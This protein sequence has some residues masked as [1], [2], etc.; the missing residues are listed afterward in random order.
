MEVEQT[1]GKEGSVWV[2]EYSKRDS[3]GHYGAI[4]KNEPGVLLL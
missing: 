2:S 3:K 4:V 1:K